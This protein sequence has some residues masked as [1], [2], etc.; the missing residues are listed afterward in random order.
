MGSRAEVLQDVS[1]GAGDEEAVAN[2]GDGDAAG[3][4]GCDRLM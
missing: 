3:E 1:G 4:D 2:R